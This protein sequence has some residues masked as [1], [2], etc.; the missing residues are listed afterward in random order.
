M[1]TF[2]NNNIALPDNDD[3]CF[4][5]CDC[6]GCVIVPTCGGCGVA[7]V[8]CDEKYIEI[9]DILVFASICPTGCTKCSSATIC[10]A[11]IATYSLNY[12]DSLCYLTC[13][14]ATYLNGT[15]YVIGGVPPGT[16]TYPGYIYSAQSY[17][18]P[19]PTLCL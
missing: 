19:C 8:C 13:P 10:S 3:G 17:C 9:R 7:S 14:Q 5:S 18:V 6:I 12:A 11:C 4:S 2:R 16:Y 15:M 1:L